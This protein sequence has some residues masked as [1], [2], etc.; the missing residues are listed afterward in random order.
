MHVVMK[1]SRRRNQWRHLADDEVVG[2]GQVTVSVPR[3][4]QQRDTLLAR[5]NAVGVRLTPGDAVTDIVHDLDRLALVV[6][7]I[8]D[9][10]DGRS[11]T[12]ARQLRERF[13][14]RGELRALPARRD[15]LGLLARCGIDSFEMH[16]QEDAAAALATL[17]RAVVA[18]QPA[19]DGLEPIFRRR[20]QPAAFPVA[21]TGAEQP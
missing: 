4:V 1:N 2:T 17:Q 6:L 12:Q 21:H 3:W 14:Y 7:D 11:Y 13:G 20:R 10:L 8:S 5:F 19:A 15:H 16:P 18:Y 9:Y